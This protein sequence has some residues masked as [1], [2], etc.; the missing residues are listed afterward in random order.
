MRTEKLT[1]D[2][3]KEL[4]IAAIQA[5]CEEKV[6]AD[7]ANLRFVKEAETYLPPYE[8][9]CKQ[10]AL[11][12]SLARRNSTSVPEVNTSSKKPPDP[13]PYQNDYSD[14]NEEYMTGPEAEQ[15]PSGSDNDVSHDAEATT[16]AH[17]AETD[18]APINSQMQERGH[19]S[20]GRRPHLQQTG[21]GGL[22]KSFGK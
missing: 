1:W 15:P 7:D 20:S 2:E 19:R 5:Y 9:L 6:I 8:V 12:R 3:F 13:D 11:A 18:N 17:P 4:Y 16:A 14:D 22:A 21:H 10:K